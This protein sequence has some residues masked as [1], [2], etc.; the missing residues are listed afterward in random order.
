MAQFKRWSGTPRP[1]I[2]PRNSH[3]N[4][5]DELQHE[6]SSLGVPYADVMCARSKGLTFLREYLDANKTYIDWK[7]R[8]SKVVIWE[9]EEII[10]GHELKPYLPYWSFVK[11]EFHSRLHLGENS[12]IYDPDKLADRIIELHD[13]V[14]HFD[15][16]D[17]NPELEELCHQYATRYQQ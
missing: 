17:K 11:K 2:R 5:G 6:L 12:I 7:E 15:E 13:A 4:I 3:R 14:H 16:Q 1:D 10:F 9:D 8:R